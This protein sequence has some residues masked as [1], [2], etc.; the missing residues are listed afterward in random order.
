MKPLEHRPEIPQT[1]KQQ[2][3]CPDPGTPFV[4]TNHLPAI[5]AHLSQHPVRH[6]QRRRIVQQPASLLHTAASIWS[7]IRP[8]PKK[9]ASLPFVSSV[10][11]HPLDPDV[12]LHSPD[13]DACIC[14]GSFRLWFCSKSMKQICP[15]NP[16]SARPASSS[17]VSLPR[18]FRPPNPCW[19]DASVRSPSDNKIGLSPAIPNPPATVVGSVEDDLPAARRQLSDRRS[20]RCPSTPVRRC[21]PARR[22]LLVN[23]RQPRSATFCRRPPAA[24]ALITDQWS[25]LLFGE[26]DG[27]PDGVLQ[28][29]TKFG[30]PSGNFGYSS[31]AHDSVHLQQHIC[32]GISSSATSSAAVTSAVSSTSISSGPRPTSVS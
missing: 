8:D 29:C 3:D 24:S 10:C 2:I 9:P 4:S 20:S 7:V 6:E 13:S 18:S 28:R 12:R 21:Q 23:A 27:A 1:L 22:P 16:S 30:A 25:L 15:E 17:S 19:L 14:I 5:L 32:F 11:E 26:E 31:G